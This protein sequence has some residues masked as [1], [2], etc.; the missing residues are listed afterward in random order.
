MR[1]IYIGLF[2]LF[3]LVATVIADTIHFQPTGRATFLVGDLM[4]VAENAGSTDSE[5]KEAI[6]NFVEELGM[7]FDITNT[8]GTTR[9]YK[10]KTDVTWIDYGPNVI[11]SGE[12]VPG[13]FPIEVGPGATYRINAQELNDESYFKS[14]MDVDSTAIGDWAK[15]NYDANTIL[16][17]GLPDLT[18]KY[19]LYLINLDGGATV[20]QETATYTQPKVETNLEILNLYDKE[21]ISLSNPYPEFRWQ[22]LRVRQGVDALYT[23]KVWKI[24]NWG[25]P[26]VDGSEI[27]NKT[28]ENVSSMVYPSSAE[29]LLP[30]TKYAWI[31]SAVD[32]TGRQIAVNKYS[33]RGEF[34]ADKIY[35]P[36]LVSPIGDQMQY[37]REFK[38][39]SVKYAAKYKIHLDKNA[40]FGN[41]KVYDTDLDDRFGVEDPIEPGKTY[42]W[43]VQAL[44]QSGEP[45]GDKSKVEKFILNTELELKAPYQDSIVTILPPEFSWSSLLGADSYKLEIKNG[46]SGSKIYEVSDTKLIPDDY[47]FEPESRYYWQVKAYNGGSEWGKASATTYFN[48]PGLP[49]PTLRSPI[50]GAVVNTDYPQFSFDLVNWATN[51]KIQVS[52]ENGNW[53]SSV[54]FDATQS[55]AQYPQSAV[56]IVRGKT[57]YWRVTPFADNGKSYNKV[58][59]VGYF[60]SKE[61]P[62]IK[63]V[64]PVDSIISEFPVVLKWEKIEKAEKYKVRYGQNSSLSGVKEVVVAGSEYSVEGDLIPGLYYWGV[65]AL[66]K[67]GNNYGALSQIASFKVLAKEEVQG[68]EIL[69]PINEMLPE[70]KV[71][72]KWLEVKGA[73]NYLVKVGKAQDLSDASSHQVADNAISG[74]KLGI[75][76]KMKEKYYWQVQAFKKNEPIGGPSKIGA[77]TFPYFTIKN[78]AP[79]SK[80]FAENTVQFHWDSIPEASGY[81]VMLGEGSELANMI[82]VKVKENKT[83]LTGL[84]YGKNYTW[85]VQA[86]DENGESY[87][88]ESPKGQFSIKAKAEAVVTG[89]VTA[90]VKIEEKKEEEKKKSTFEEASENDVKKFVQYLRDYLNKNN[91]G[92]VLQGFKLSEAKMSEGKINKLLLEAIMNGDVKL[93]SVKVR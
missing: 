65:Q 41:E 54:M 20:A 37:P 91:Q 73:T 51:Y 39:K 34:I 23:V 32:G 90:N 86:V 71:H 40:D 2:L 74:E 53:E 62:E 85:Y 67:E 72:L 56:E 38:W 66:D 47:V 48:T 30:N 19:T 43:Y 50:G 9:N 77:F 36:E 80:E 82:T 22:L 52:K 88:G 7:Y 93:N 33:E 61:V 44:D 84:L 55:P 18:L 31:V 27:V 58:S 13:S 21:E 78:I 76:F 87:G 28:V 70:M 75:A 29:P 4:K 81:A 46:S 1:K 68:T 11:A 6:T 60:G 17:S 15:N 35:P 83:Q 3:V 79:N 16:L 45:W 12:T 8:S 64:S 14:L 49:V 89:S 24:K 25:D 69:Y 42:Y 59:E 92:L 63:L 57:Y 26:L 5:I 10:V